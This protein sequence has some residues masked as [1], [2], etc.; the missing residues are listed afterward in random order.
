[1]PGL[2]IESSTLS[3]R[4]SRLSTK[5]SLH[6]L[7]V[8]PGVRPSALTTRLSLHPECYLGICYNCSNFIEILQAPLE[9]SKSENELVNPTTSERGKWD[10]K[11]EFVLASLGFA[12]GLGNVWRFPWMCWKNGG[13]MLGCTKQGW[14]V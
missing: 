6:P 8:T 1:M 3:I 5:P 7:P 9:P 12:V 13:G 14:Y 11:A 2:V 10:S 4:P